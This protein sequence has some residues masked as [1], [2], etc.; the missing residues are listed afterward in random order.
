[1]DRGA[2]FAEALPGARPSRQFRILPDVRRPAHDCQEQSVVHGVAADYQSAERS[3]DVAA[4][5]LPTLSQW[6]HVIP[7][8]VLP[9]EPTIAKIKQT[10]ILKNF[11]LDFENL[12]N[13][14][15]CA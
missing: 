8:R 2:V 14:Y 15:D 6:H 11:R 13:Y 3:G 5:R 9:D 12:P 7:G 4:L 10:Q 1:M